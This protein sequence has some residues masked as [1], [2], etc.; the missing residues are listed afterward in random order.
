M[1]AAHTADIIDRFTE[2]PSPRTN[3]LLPAQ[4]QMESA[5]KRFLFGAMEVASRDLELE[6]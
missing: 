2:R 1:S 6:G 3:H 4:R 5:L